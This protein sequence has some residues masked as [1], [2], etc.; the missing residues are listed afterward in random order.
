MKF[1]LALSVAIV[2]Q[3]FK[4]IFGEN[5]TLSKVNQDIAIRA[6]HGSFLRCLFLQYPFLKAY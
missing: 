6:R 2:A 1:T 3:I 4:R 5:T